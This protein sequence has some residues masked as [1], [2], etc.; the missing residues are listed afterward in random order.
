MLHS[1]FFVAALRT[2]NSKTIRGFVRPLVRWS[3]IKS[4]S[5][6]TRI[7]DATATGVIVCVCERAWG[8]KGMGV[9]RP[10]PPRHPFRNDIVTPHH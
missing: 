1:Y 10:C 8:G 3:M 4:V 2:R 6:K 7:F 5:V 9:V